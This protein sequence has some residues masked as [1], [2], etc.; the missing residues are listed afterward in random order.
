MRLEAARSNSRSALMNRTI[1]FSSTDNQFHEAEASLSH[2]TNY[3]IDNNKSEFKSKVE[4][5]TY[6]E[7]VTTNI[8]LP[9]HMLHDKINRQHTVSNLLNLVH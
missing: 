3:F 2:H 4:K 8:Q 9:D 6:E 1:D 7:H 5:E